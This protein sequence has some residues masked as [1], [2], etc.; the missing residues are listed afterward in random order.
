[1]I[2]GN[3]GNIT[4][5]C[6]VGFWKKNISGNIGEIL[7]KSTVQQSMLISFDHCTKAA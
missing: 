2:G 3:E 7:I 5:K 6:N 4:N 1:M